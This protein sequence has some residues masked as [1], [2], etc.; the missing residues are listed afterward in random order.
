MSELF[1]PAPYPAY[2]VGAPMRVVASAGP[3]GFTLVNG[4]PTI[5]SWLCP[6]D[7]PSHRLVVCS[8]Q[9]VG[10]L[11][12]G[13]AVTVTW[14]DPG[15]TSRA[16]IIYAGGLAAGLALPSPQLAVAIQGGQLV[17]VTQ[18]SALTGGSGTAWIELLADV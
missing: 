15:G 12:T 3:A 9:N 18:S 10:S 4:T 7:M 14:K 11:Q 5:L 16:S 2:P 13:G 1:Q 6:I 8:S 17:T